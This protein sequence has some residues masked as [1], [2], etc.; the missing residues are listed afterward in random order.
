MGKN[1]NFLY[2][3]EGACEEKLLKTLKTDMQLIQPGKILKCNV[4][5]TKIKRAQL[6]TLKNRTTVVLVFDTDT[7][8]TIILRQNIDMLNK[9]SAISRVICIT[10]VDNLEDELERSCDVHNVYE[11]TNSKSVDSFKHDFINA[12]N[13]KTTL[14]NHKFC[15]DKLWIKSPKNKQ[16]NGIVNEAD[17]IKNDTK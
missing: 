16:Y 6:K 12:S 15:F 17:F 7:E 4:M 5:Q 9:Q 2:Y 13:L 10:Q 11:I 3:V 8:N 14:E 1:N